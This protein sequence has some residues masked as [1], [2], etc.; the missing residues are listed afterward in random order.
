MGQPATSP[1][2]VGSQI[3][4]R[5]AGSY[6]RR[7]VVLLLDEIKKNVTMLGR[8]GIKGLRTVSI[9]IQGTPRD[10]AQ[11]MARCLEAVA[12]PTTSK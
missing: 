2:I 10:S 6:K 11:H 4:E 1:E 8:L 5:G 12:G 3:A 7:Q 9:A